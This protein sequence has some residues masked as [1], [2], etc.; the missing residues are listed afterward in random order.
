MNGGYAAALNGRFEK[1]FCGI[2][3]LK[4]LTVG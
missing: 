3:G 4:T 1:G 2:V